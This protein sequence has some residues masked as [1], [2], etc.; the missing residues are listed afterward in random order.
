MHLRLLDDLLNILVVLE[1]YHPNIGGVEQLF[2]SLCEGFVR[3]GHTVTVLTAAVPSHPAEENVNGVTIR[4]LATQSRYLFSLFSLPALRHL[5]PRCDIILT[6]SYN[7]A[8]PAWIAAVWYRKKVIITFHEIWG[9]LW[10]QLPFFGWIRKLGH[11]AFEQLLL[12]LSFDR[13]IAPSRATETGLIEQGIDA[14]RITQIYNGINYDHLKGYK[15]GLSELFSYSYFGRFGISKGLDI[16]LPA[17]GRF[18]KQHPRSRLNLI[19]PTRPIRQH[20][21][22]MRLIAQY[23]LQQHVHIQHDLSKETLYRTITT[24]HCVVIPS[25]S[26]GF[27]FAAVEAIAL[28]VPVVT[29]NRGALPEVVSGKHIIFAEL[30]SDAL[31]NA[32]VQAMS[33]SWTSTE[34]K[35]FSIEDTIRGYMDLIDEVVEL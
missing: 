18:V 17:A 14:T 19:I 2:T 13:F 8:L 1:S 11:Y 28:G 20:R 30:T 7:A 15:H 3:Q 32:L 12:R 25:Y 35:V 5:A 33:G 22:I 31:Y 26:E 29:S 21:R 34:L 23:G 27:C 10:F 24:S 6:T 16:L 9:K 4:H